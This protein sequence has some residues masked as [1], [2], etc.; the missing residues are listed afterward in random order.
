[1]FSQLRRYKCSV[2]IQP[3]KGK[4]ARTAGEPV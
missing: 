4:N 1:V 3:W 2:H